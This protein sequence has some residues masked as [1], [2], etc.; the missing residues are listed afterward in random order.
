MYQDVPRLE[1]AIDNVGYAS[2]RAGNRTT[3]GAVRDSNRRLRRPVQSRDP[4]NRSGYGAA[5]APS[6]RR[7]AARHTLH[8]GPR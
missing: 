3:F 8:G 1:L 5:A 6:P 2:N 7:N 4:A